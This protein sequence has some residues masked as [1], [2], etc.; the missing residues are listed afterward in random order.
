VST[1]GVTA[2]IA[3][4]VASDRPT[5]VVVPTPGRA[6]ELEQELA[7]FTGD[8]AV[9]R[10]PEREFVPYEPGTEERDSWLE[11]VRA[12][13]FLGSDGAVVV[14]ASWPALAEHTPG[15]A[16]TAERIEL[17][18]G[19][20]GTPEGLVR[21][22]ESMGYIVEPVADRPG[23]VARRGGVV[24]VFPTDQVDPVRI[25]YFGNEVDSL[26]TLDLT[27]QRSTGR[28]DRVAFTSAATAS[29]M[30][31]TVAAQ[32]ARSLDPTTDEAERLIEELAT[33]AE[34][35]RPRSQ[36]LMS[37]LLNDGCALDHLAPGA[38]VVVDDW[39]AGV[40]A[41][42]AA[43]DR[44]RDTQHALESRGRIPTGLPPLMIEAERIER[45]LRATKPIELDRFGDGTD[46][47][48]RLPIVTPQTFGGRLRE[49]VDQVGV[50]SGSG[51]PVVVV[52]QQALRIADLLEEAGIAHALSSAVTD[53]PTGGAVVLAPE[54]LASGLI[55]QDM[56]VVISDTEIFGYRKRR[57]PVSHI[58]RLRRDLLAEI[59]PGDYLVHIDH[60]VARFAGL[61]TREVDGI[62]REYLELEYAERD[63]LYVP[64][65][66]LQLVER[67]VG[68]SDRPPSLTRLGTQ[69]WAHAKRRVRHAV[70]EIAHD[71]LDLY[72]QRE[73]AVGHRYAPDGPWQMELEASFPFVETEDQRRAI[74]EVKADMESPRPM[75]RLICGDV[76]FGKT[77]VAVRA[78]F[79][80]IAD[81]KQAAILVPTTVLAEQHGATFRERLAGF[82]VRVEVL[83][84]FRSPEQQREILAGLKSGDVDTVIGTHRLL[85]NDVEFNDLGLVI[86]DEEQRFGVDQKE[87]L[88]KMRSQVDV[89]SM[90]ATPIPRT[91]QM[92]LSGIREMSTVMT[93]PEER[94]PVQTYVTE[95][96]DDILREAIRRELDRGG[97]VY[98]VHNRVHN[99]E[100]IAR[101]IEEL[102]PEANI[103][104]GHG[105]MPEEQLERVMSEFAAGEHDV[106]LCTTIIESG[107][108]IP[109]VNTII[110]NQAD[111]FG[112]SQLYQLRGRV[113]RGSHRAY[114]YLVHSRGR[115]LSED[116]QKRLEA[117][118]E[119][120]QL[121]AGLQIALRDL[122][123]RGAGNL[124]GT[125]QSGH[126]AAVGFDLYTRLL[127]DA[128]RALGGAP[129]ATEAPEEAEA[130]SVD[131][132][133]SAFLPAGYVADMSERLALYQRISRASAPADV[134]AMQDELR[135][136]YGPLPPA[137]EHL[138]YVTLVRILASRAGVE[139]IA[140]DEQFIHAYLRQGTT[141]AQQEAVRHLALPGIIVG[142]RQI[143]LA[144]PEAG[145]GWTDVLIR[146]LRAA[147]L[148]RKVIDP[149]GAVR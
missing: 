2:T 132:P 68:P 11:R 37:A 31:R 5:L 76:G 116:A 49:F 95:W 148:P 84:R 124:L 8:V 12:L 91:M 10:L 90:S 66:Q 15:P 135:D 119:A 23:T 87:R 109:N 130:M 27:T 99:I 60:G 71:L 78:A 59:Q 39:A 128:V 43:W 121:G 120:T 103:V 125:N 111:M 28:T 47:R 22:L 114:C 115:S 44:E 18:P 94:L 149:V 83:S 34:G 19:D 123:I 36:A 136:R 88:K 133:I 82:P 69:E 143:R 21:Q 141:S 42:E 38:R 45:A 50:W 108:D 113:G 118:F 32:L 101:E 145:E 67:Y 41:L 72:A 48:D 53:P 20:S 98:F 112:L 146:A 26:R 7:L 96:N 89:L 122:E 14:V 13:D 74:G 57:R 25:E 9:H 62:E 33:I 65:D 70:A 46:Q 35:A 93:P 75:D 129:A 92:A 3:A 104:I 127:G 106:L 1:S 40:T 100:M 63:R 56:L 58:P 77:E 105:Q 131:L 140:T 80:A 85:Q 4:L 110:I 17:S 81:G 6:Q 79:K 144:R 73:M 64:T 107:L 29:D 117:V 61:I 142:P 138:L 126:I 139:R 51:L 54:A 16:R 137:A 52:S 147:A 134:A 86:I 30:A 55:V 24:D 102:V 97:Q